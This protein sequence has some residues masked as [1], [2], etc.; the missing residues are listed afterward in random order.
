MFSTSRH[1]LRS[2]TGQVGARLVADVE[3]VRPGVVRGI[4]R[5]LDV[6]G[7]DRVHDLDAGL[8]LERLQKPGDDVL[9]VGPERGLRELERDAV[10]RFRGSH[11]DPRRRDGVSGERTGGRQPDRDACGPLEELAPA[12]RCRL[13]LR[14][15]RQRIRGCVHPNRPQQPPSPSG[16]ARCSGRSAYP[17]LT[18]CGEASGAILGTYM[19][20]IQ[21]ESTL[22]IGYKRG[23]L[24]RIRDV[25]SAPLGR[26]ADALGAGGRRHRRRR[27]IGRA[28]WP[29]SPRPAPRWSSPTSTSR[30]RGEAADALGPPS[31]RASAV[32]VARRGGGARPLAD[33]VGRRGSGASTSG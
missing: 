6:P 2:E 4:R 22:S 29:G 28:C 16:L 7:D 23:P 13:G 21:V 30:R 8:V 31:S 11:A 32:D 9:L 27:G 19:Q 26:P 20:R 10:E 1:A 17:S 14:V 15:G 12:V 18:A 24:G 3:R 25:L 33:A 5:A